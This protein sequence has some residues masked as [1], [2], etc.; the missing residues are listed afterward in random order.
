MHFSFF[1]LI[2]HAAKT[3]D[4]SAGTIIGSGTVSNESRAVGSSCI[5]EQRM[6]EILDTGAPSTPYLKDGDSVEI[7]MLDRG[8]DIFGAISQRVRMK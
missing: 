3:R 2:E 5:V 8:R 1:D 4:L 7:V 6:R